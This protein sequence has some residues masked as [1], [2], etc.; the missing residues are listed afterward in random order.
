MLGRPISA[1]QEEEY[2]S[3]EHLEETLSFLVRSA[4]Q[5]LWEGL[6]RE[7]RPCDGGEG[8]PGRVT[9]VVK[10]CQGYLLATEYP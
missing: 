10:P 9:F 4:A 6:G 8:P 7:V 3:P 1:S 2:T 5:Y